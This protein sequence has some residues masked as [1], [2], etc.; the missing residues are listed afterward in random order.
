LLV[1]P[2]CGGHLRLIAL[3]EAPVVQ[4]TLRHL[5]LPADLLEPLPSRG[6]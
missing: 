4:R 3:D 5:A 1:C 2:H 6:R